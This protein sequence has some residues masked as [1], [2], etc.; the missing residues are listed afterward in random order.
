MKNRP[1]PIRQVS[2]HEFFATIESTNAHPRV[3]T[4]TLKDRYHVSN[5]E[6]PA[7]AV[8]GQL[9]SDSWGVEPSR[10]FLP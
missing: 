1:G 9:I 2:S 4:Q 3:E 8:V 7:R 5:F 10:F 6:T